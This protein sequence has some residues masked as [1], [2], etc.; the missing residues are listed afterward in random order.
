MDERRKF[1]LSYALKFDPLETPY[2]TEYMNSADVRKALHIPD[3]IQA[4][5]ICN[6]TIL[7]DYMS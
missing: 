4:F 7:Y 6:E 1:F 5:D 3:S 2:V